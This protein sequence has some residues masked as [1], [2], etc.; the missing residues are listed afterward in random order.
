MNSSLLTN[1][2]NDYGYFGIA[3]LLALEN[4]FPPIPSEIILGFTGF[5]TISSNLDIFGSIIAATI[6]A[7]I[8]ALILYFLAKSFQLAA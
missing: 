6:G 5:L 3:L 1:L 2:I 4:I 8:G 7:L